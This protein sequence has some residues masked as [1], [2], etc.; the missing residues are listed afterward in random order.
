VR[1]RLADAEPLTGADREQV[2]DTVR[3]SLETFLAPAES[4]PAPPVAGPLTE[5]EVSP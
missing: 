4:N 2:I 3:Q 5:A 1:A